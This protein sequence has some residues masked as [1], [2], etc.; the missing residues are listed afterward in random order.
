MLQTKFEITTILGRRRRE[1]QKNIWKIYPLSLRDLAGHLDL[2]HRIIRPAIHDP[3][4][5]L[6]V[7]HQQVRAGNESCENLRMREIDAIAIA[8]CRIEVEPEL[9]VEG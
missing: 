6:A 7:V 5:H 2:G 4:H 9:A 8:W 3:E 1:R